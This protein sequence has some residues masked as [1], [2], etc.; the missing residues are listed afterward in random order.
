MTDVMVCFADNQRSAKSR[1]YSGRRRFDFSCV[2]P[3]RCKE[4]D[5]SSKLKTP[6]RI[7]YQRVSTK[8]IY[9]E[10]Y[11]AR[12]GRQRAMDPET[13]IRKA[14]EHVVRDVHVMFPEDVV[15]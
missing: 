8:T 15:K 9:Y 3:C 2:L 11:P 13:F 5:N 1:R 7:K 4:S 12:F 10:Y 14:F 6:L